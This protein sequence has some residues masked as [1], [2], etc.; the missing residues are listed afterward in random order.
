MR[1]LFASTLLL[2]FV[3]C[4]QTLAADNPYAGT[5]KL[6]LEKSKGPTPACLD[7]GILVIPPEIFTGAAAPNQDTRLTKIKS[8]NC[9]R[10]VYK[11]TASPDGRALTLTQ[12]QIDPAFRAVFDRQ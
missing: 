1:I 6:N 10:R 2:G 5:W 4:L 8:P 9:F 3:L 11:F 12:P 7:N